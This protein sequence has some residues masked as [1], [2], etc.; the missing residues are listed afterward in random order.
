MTPFHSK[1]RRKLRFHYFCSGATAWQHW[2]AAA[3]SNYNLGKRFPKKH[4]SDTRPT[5]STGL[6]NATAAALATAAGKRPRLLGEGLPQRIAASGGLQAGRCC[7]GAAGGLAGESRARPRGFGQ[8]GHC[9]PRW[10]WLQRSSTAAP[11]DVAIDCFIDL[12][13][14][15]DKD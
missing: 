14:G 5:G 15:L 12:S 6:L 9:K 3:R 11:E 7:G 2:R 1:R 4:V 13:R 10:G 8:P